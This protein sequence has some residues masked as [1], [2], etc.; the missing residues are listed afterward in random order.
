MAFSR[1][2]LVF[3]SVFLL[4]STPLIAQDV[5]FKSANVLDIESGK[6]NKNQDVLVRGGKI[7]SIGSL[8][9]RPE[10]IT[11]ASTGKYLVPGFT[12]MH[13]H[14][15]PSW[16]GDSK[17]N[18]H[19]F[20]FNA[21]GI[22]TIRGMLGHPSHLKVRQ[23]LKNN[24][25]SGPRLITSGPSFNGNSVVSKGQAAKR[26]KAQYEK[27]YDF[28]KIHPGMSDA[29]F[30]S[31][32]KQARALEFDFS[33]HVTAET[34][35]LKSIELGQGTIEHLDGI[36][37]E[38]SLRSGN[39][40]VSSMGFF[41]TGL[42]N[43]IDRKQIKRLASELAQSNVHLIPTQTMVWGLISPEKPSELAKKPKYKLMTDSELN[44]W[45]RI[46][47]RIQNDEYYS[48]ELIAEYMSIRLEFLKEYIQAG[49]RILLGAD[50][51]QVFNI[52]GESLHE[53]MIWMRDAGMS[54]I[55]ILRSTTI[56]PAKFF[57]RESEFGSIKA[58]K[59]A[60]LV[61]LDA[62]PLND[63]SNTREIAGVMTRGVW[64]SKSEIG[65]RLADMRRR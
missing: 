24:E 63:I 4:V 23:Q 51:P 20:L 52:P 2:R 14:V 25:I 19:L 50:A 57:K 39:R 36:F 12:E 61:L 42:V 62:N 6:F 29:E 10:M 34:G 44:N 33:G 32:A 3:T 35:I 47:T 59:S 8:K 30:Q 15:R 49:G 38:L 22:T 9:A 26:A 40:D 37:A 7:V 16:G 27:G 48:K 54:A 21:F 13:A 58:G 65:K 31:V 60:D 43:T 46:K 11:I 53:E 18:E 1:L 17:L 5:L 45:K 56:Q 55:E 28:I 41:G 64:L